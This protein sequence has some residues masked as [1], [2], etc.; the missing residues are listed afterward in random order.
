MKKKILHLAYLDKF[1]PGFIELIL[2]RFS[3]EPHTMLTFGDIKKYYY[4]QSISMRNFSTLKSFRAILEMIC[5][6][7]SNDK[8]ILHGLFSSNL[9][10]LLCFMPWLHSKCA[11]II[12]GG[13]L[14]YHKLA[15]KNF[16]YHFSEIFRK[17]LISRLGGFITY[18]EGDYHNA[19]QW[20]KANGKLYEC[21]MYKSNVYSG[22]V[23]TED[24]LTQSR[25]RDSIKINIQVGNSADPTNNHLKVFEQ[26]VKLDVQNCVGKIYCP[27]SYGNPVYAT[28]IKQL[29]VAMFGEKFCPLM[30]FM[31]LA[32]Y[33]EILNEVD[34][35]IFAHNRQQAMGNTINL[36]GRGKTV[37]MHTDTSS[38]RLLTKLGIKVFS[39]DD[40]AL[41]VQPSDIAIANNQLVR[42][43]FS[44]DNLVS[45]LK[46]IF[47]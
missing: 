18:I 25:V 32:Q 24:D 46:S 2:Q 5:A 38:Y 13:D 35:A 27:L 20:Y 23:L 10:M 12:W 15:K 19:Q 40:L 14:Y 21:I 22:S 39:L 1:I 28:Q 31:P 7:H 41:T 43:Y 6:M 30:D 42:N 47:A 17:F 11:W 16:R 8:I 37:Y 26:L 45:Q 9:V 44:E 3:D 29:G 36:L 34:I 4:E 33:N